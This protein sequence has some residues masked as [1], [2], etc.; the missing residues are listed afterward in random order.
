MEDNKVQTPEVVSEVPVTPV[1]P[2]VEVISKEDMAVLDKAGQNKLLSKLEA[3]KASARYESADLAQR[4][5][6][7]QIYLKYGLAATDSFNESDGTF[8]RMPK[9]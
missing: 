5:V 4:N 1:E 9:G 7:L 6:V 2:Q 3:E 8:K